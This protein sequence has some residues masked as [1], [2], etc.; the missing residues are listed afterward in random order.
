MFCEIIPSN[1]NLFQAAWFEL[2][3]INDDYRAIKHRYAYGVRT[4]RPTD[5]RV[6]G[7][8]SV[9]NQ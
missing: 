7:K 1:I 4:I 3:N 5:K 2:P 8:C 9:F 6:S